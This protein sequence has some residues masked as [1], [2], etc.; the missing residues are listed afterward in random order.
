MLKPTSAAAIATEHLDFLQALEAFK[1]IL[2]EYPT[3]PSYSDGMPQQDDVEDT[4]ILQHGEIHQIYRPHNPLNQS[5]RHNLNLR[6]PE[7]MSGAPLGRWCR[8]GGEGCLRLKSAGNIGGG[9]GG[10]I[11]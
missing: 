4:S 1:Q 7:N 9:T 11:A 10:K 5:F 6:L 2:Q 3:A 8:S